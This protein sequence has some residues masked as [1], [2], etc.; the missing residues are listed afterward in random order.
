[1]EKHR[2]CAK[3]AEKH[4]DNKTILYNSIRKYGIGNFVFS[5]IETIETD[6]IS[7]LNEKEVFWIS[8]YN[9]LS[10]NG[11]NMTLGGPGSLGMSDEVRLKI[12]IANSGKNIQKS[13][14]KK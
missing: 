13:I 3:Y 6:D 9:S 11:Y 4:K 7:I 2:W 10:P 5:V 1:M 12:S 8:H 14:L